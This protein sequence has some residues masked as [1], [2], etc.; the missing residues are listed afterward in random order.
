MRP[1][2]SF[3]DQERV[4]LADRCEPLIQA[5]DAGDLELHAVGRHEYPG[6]KL[7]DSE[8]VGLSSV[9]FWNAEHPQ[10]WGL[11]EHRNEGIEFTFMDTGH[12]PVRVE[13]N[14]Q[15]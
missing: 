3:I 14:A 9:G 12:L 4:Y 11:P 8:L 2:P 5:A 15:T 10:P 6:A 7:K 13:G 1:N